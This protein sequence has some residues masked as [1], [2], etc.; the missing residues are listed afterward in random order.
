M[1]QMGIFRSPRS[2]N[3]SQEEKNVNNVHGAM[4][5]T[6]EKEL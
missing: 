3:P 4:E 2:T 6:W 5:V 1:R